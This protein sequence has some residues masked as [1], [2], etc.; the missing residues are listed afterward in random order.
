MANTQIF[1]NAR[2]EELKAILT[3]MKAELKNARAAKDTLMVEIL[4]EG[5]EEFEDE[6]AELGEEV[7]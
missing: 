4:T 1:E 5:I 2:I 6:L 3:K 7:N